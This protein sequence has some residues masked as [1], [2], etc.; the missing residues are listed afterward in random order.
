MG[1]ETAEFAYDL[2]AGFA[3]LQV[4]E[5]DDLTLVGMAANLAVHI[6][7]VGEIP[8]EVLRKVCDHFMNI[9][10]YALKDVLKLLAEVEFVRIISTRRSIEKII[11]NIPIFDDVYQGLGDYIDASCSLNEH[12][13]ATIRILSSL[14][15]APYNKDS[16]EA[17]L[18]IEKPVFDRC[19]TLGTSSGIVSSH[20]ARGQNILISPYY[21][22]D[23]LSGL[24][25][26]AA[27]SKTP[28][29]KTALA[30]IK[31]NQG[32][33]LS[34]L[35]STGEIGGVALSA[36]EV[37]L[38]KKLA[39]EGIV[40]PPSI[41]F[42]VVTESFLFTPKPGE[43][44]LNAGNREIYERSMALVSAV[45]KGQLLADEYKIRSPLRILESLGEKGYLRSNSE[46]KDQYQN[47]VVLRVAKL[48]QVTPTRWELHLIRTSENESALKLAVQL[49]RTGALAN[50]EVDED[51]RIALSKDETYVQSLIA[52]KEMKVREK[53]ITN[54]QAEDEFQQLLLL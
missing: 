45:R 16:L 2:Q 30:K 53:Q 47:L 48:K 11:P 20:L 33:P 51:A 7:G 37:A 18:G 36:T 34:L 9:P 27:S 6:K 41:K 54:P 26:I 8:Y 10:S 1:R 32:W 12:E 14:Q 35:E 15:D 22:T 39:S 46:A 4:S 5:F 28:N 19:I 21:F 17:N 13:Q 44:R 29:L 52:S 24:A 50:M 49:L 31:D 3:S 25:D 38:V 42:G 40:K 43:T 23:N